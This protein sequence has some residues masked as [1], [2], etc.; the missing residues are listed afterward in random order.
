MSEILCFYSVAYFS[1]QC[2]HSWSQQ[3]KQDSISLGSMPVKKEFWL[4]VC[5]LLEK[6]KE[7]IETNEESDHYSAYLDK[8]SG[9]WFDSPIKQASKFGHTWDKNN[10]TMRNII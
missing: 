5:M 1:M 10:S 3:G 8:I 6:S 7:R 2:S 4:I 9:A